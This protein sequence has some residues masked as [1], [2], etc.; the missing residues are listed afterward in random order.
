MESC[1]KND[2]RVWS[3]VVSNETDERLSY[4]SSSMSCV[5]FELEP[6][7]AVM[8][9]KLSSST[10]PSSRVP[11]EEERDDMDDFRTRFKSSPRINEP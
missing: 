8:L 1:S 2:G 11:D 9:H 7:E 3:R 6:S 4:S 5:S 10:V